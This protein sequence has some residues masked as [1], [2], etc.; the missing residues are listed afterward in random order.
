VINIGFLLF[1]DENNIS[2]K[3]EARLGHDIGRRPVKGDNVTF[4]FRYLIGM[5]IQGK[6]YYL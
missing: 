5:N 1:H 6:I 3:F 2:D 4:P